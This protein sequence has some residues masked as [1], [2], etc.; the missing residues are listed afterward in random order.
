MACSYSAVAAAAN[1]LH[2]LIAQNSTKPVR[3]LQPGETY[4]GSIESVG[5]DY[6]CTTRMIRSATVIGP[7]TGESKPHVQCF[8]FAA[9]QSV[10]T[11]GIGPDFLIVH[12]R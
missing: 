3:I 5:T 11:K 10:V 12:I 7:E 8:P 2:D 4:E 6:F 1:S 9:I